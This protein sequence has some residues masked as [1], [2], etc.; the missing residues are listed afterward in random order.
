MET[1]FSVSA[2]CSTFSGSYR[3][4]EEWK[5][6]QKIW[7]LYRGMFRSY[8]TYEEWKH[9]NK[10]ITPAFIY[11]VLT[12]PMRNGNIFHKSS[13]EIAFLEFLPYLWGMETSVTSMKNVSTHKV[14]TVPM[15]NGNCVTCHEILKDLVRSYRTYEEWKLVVVN[16]IPIIYK[17]LPYLW[18]METNLPRICRKRRICSYRTY[19]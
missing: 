9:K 17:F 4:Y 2:R 11:F 1:R 7:Q 19:E 12:V 13:P 18:G 10:A 16:V 14:L 6:T 3:T 8:R 5:Q 15:R